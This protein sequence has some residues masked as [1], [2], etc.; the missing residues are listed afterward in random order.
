MEN[1]IQ[2]INR[3]EKGTKTPPTI[4]ENKTKT[5]PVIVKTKKASLDLSTYFSDNID[6]EK[7]KKESVDNIETKKEDIPVLDET[8]K[9]DVQV[10]DETKKDSVEFG[11]YFKEIISKDKKEIVDIIDK[12]EIDDGLTESDNVVKMT[13]LITKTI[14]KINSSDRVREW[15][16]DVERDDEKLIKSISMKEVVNEN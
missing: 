1:F 8:K 4:V 5:P 15:E 13:E 6:I 3:K 2:I 10:P 16:I 14:N 12:K 7:P 11:S 9:E